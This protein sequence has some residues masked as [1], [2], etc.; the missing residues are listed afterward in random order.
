[1][2]KTYKAGR[3]EGDYSAYAIQIK[4]ILFLMES[5]LSLEEAMASV[6]MGTESEN[7][8]I[9]IMK[10]MLFLGLILIVSQKL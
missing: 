6:E 5:S 9:M 3:R 8:R 7:S 10:S 1:V 4:Q 2:D